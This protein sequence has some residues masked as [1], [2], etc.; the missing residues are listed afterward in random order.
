MP[1]TNNQF[2]IP[3]HVREAEKLI[4]RLINTKPKKSPSIESAV[5]LLKY[6]KSCAERKDGDR[7]GGLEYLPP[8]RSA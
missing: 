1:A 7:P 3:R 5:R 2:V 6:I 4:R 8:E